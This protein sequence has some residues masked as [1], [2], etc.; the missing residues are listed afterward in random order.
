MSRGIE[1]IVF[2]MILGVMEDKTAEENI[3]M[4]IIGAMVTIE[5]GIDQDRGHSQEVIAVIEPEV[6][7]VVGQGQDLEPIP[8]RIE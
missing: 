8:I 7:A 1:G 3:K 6:Q 2:K 4:I 5:V